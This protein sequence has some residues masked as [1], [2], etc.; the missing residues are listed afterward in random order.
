MAREPIIDCD[1][2]HMIAEPEELFPY[3]PRDYVEHIQDF[4]L[5]MPGGFSTGYTNMPKGGARADVWDG[6]I[7]PANNIDMAR[8]RHLD[9]YGVAAAVL[10]GSTVY[11]AAVHPN[12]DYAAALCRA[13]ND[14]TLDTWIAADRR[15]FGSISV[16]AVDPYQAAQEI[17]RLGKHPR[18]VQVII[19]A[20]ARMPFGNRF[21]HPMYEAAQEYALPVCVHF[22]SEGTG[23]SGPPT[24]VGYPSYYLEMRMARPQNAMAHVSSLICEG[25]FEK[26]PNLRFLFVEH[27][28]FWVPGLMWHM[29]ADW[30]STREYTPWVKRLPSEY[31]RR[32]IRFGSQPMEQPPSVE[33]LKVFLRW[34]HAD[35]ILVFGSDYPHWD[36]DNPDRVLRG[37]SPQLG[38]RVFYDNA[39]ELYGDRL[40]ELKPASNGSEAG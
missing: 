40:G 25:V 14:W 24:G 31:I 30:K 15:F 26:F 39:R 34:L 13:F 21:Y 1:V 29:D 10:T 33:D 22:G 27:D 5:M 6:D 36:W 37:V 28:T 32:N 8:K 11:G 12:V 20:G 2:H 17:H 19:P 38:R 4:G 35:E 3:L 16:S 9:E 7:H 18:M 23:V